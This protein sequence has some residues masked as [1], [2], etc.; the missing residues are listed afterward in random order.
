M[1][2]HQK[3]QTDKVDLG[4]FIKRKASAV[5]GGGFDWDKTK[6]GFEY[7]NDIIIN[8]KFKDFNYNK[9]IL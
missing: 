2:Y 6:Q 4:T 5:S 1:L 9:S 8:K 7:W 3:K